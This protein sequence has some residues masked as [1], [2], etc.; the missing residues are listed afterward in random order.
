MLKSPFTNINER[1]AAFETSDIYPVISSEFCNGR[2][3]LM[4]LRAV[5]AAGAKLVQL[6]EKNLTKKD[7]YELGV[8]Y[9]KITFEYHMLLIVNDHTDLALALNADGV[10]L[11][12]DDLPLNAAQKIAPELLFGVS[13][14]NPEEAV[15]AVR[16][17]AGYI[18]I[19]PIYPTGTKQVNCG[20]V[21]TEMI[22][23]IAPA[24]PI[25]F[26]VMGGIK[27]KHIQE[28]R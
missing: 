4:I 2:D 21:G 8:E 17:G 5:A 19:G 16:D 6:R 12:Q 10:H 25:P 15:E 28:L 26:S 27:S 3:P 11:G 9:R 18:N 20:A 22:R 13:T 14:H 1:I 23:Q 24:L 7:L